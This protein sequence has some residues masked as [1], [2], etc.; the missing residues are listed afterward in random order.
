MDNQWRYIGRQR[1]PLQ[2]LKLCFYHEIT[3]YNLRWFVS[4]PPVAMPDLLLINKTMLFFDSVGIKR[5]CLAKRL[6]LKVYC[7]TL[8]ICCNCCLFA[9]S[10]S[11]SSDVTCPLPSAVF[12][13]SLS[14]SN[15]ELPAHQSVVTSMTTLTSLP[16]T[17]PFTSTSSTHVSV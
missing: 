3:D 13:G 2:L 8:I 6:S 1:L 14:G 16:P 15:S 17:A 11:S 4:H 10:Y 5:D 7:F 12:G 9:G